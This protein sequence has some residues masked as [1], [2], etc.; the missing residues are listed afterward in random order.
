MQFISVVAHTLHVQNKSQRKMGMKS[1]EEVLVDLDHACSSPLIKVLK[2]WL[3]L[4]N[5]LFNLT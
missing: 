3:I 1:E 4:I 5:I 2:G